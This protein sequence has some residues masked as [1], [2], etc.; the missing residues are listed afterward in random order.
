[1]GNVRHHKLISFF[2]IWF[3]HALCKIIVLW[4][5]EIC[6]V[7][8]YNTLIVICYSFRVLQHHSRENYKTY[9]ITLTLGV[10]IWLLYFLGGGHLC[11]FNW[12]V[13][14]AKSYEE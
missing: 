14:V 8:I 2:H 3:Y 1:M 11:Q 5:L 7:L 6:P 4:A 12:N 13:S 10:A 9:V